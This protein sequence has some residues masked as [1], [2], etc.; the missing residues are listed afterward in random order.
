MTKL[1]I[2]LTD[3]DEEVIV[4]FMKDHDE[5]YDQTSEHVKDKARKYLV[6]EEF[7]RIASC[8]S[9]Y[10]RPGLKR[11]GHITGSWTDPKQNDGMSELDTGQTKILEVAHQT[12]GAQQV[13]SLQ[14]ANLR[15][16]CFSYYST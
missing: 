6:W 13:V 9:R 7:T 14:I 4:D 2:Y 15:S 16:Q 3:S 1:N 5:L 10:V 12:Q 8:L 11:K